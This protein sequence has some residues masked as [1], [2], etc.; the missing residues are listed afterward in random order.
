MNNL[1]GVVRKLFYAKRKVKW[2]ALALFIFSNSASAGVP[3]GP[4]IVLKSAYWLPDYL[5]AALRVHGYLGERAQNV[6]EVYRRRVELLIAINQ[7]A[8]E[9]RRS[10]L[11][12]IEF[13]QGGDDLFNLPGRP[14]RMAVTGTSLGSKVIFNLGLISDPGRFG[15]N[16]ALGLWVHELGHKLKAG[17]FSQEEIDQ[18]AAFVADHFINQMQIVEISDLKF[19]VIN[20]VPYKLEGMSST[21]A[22]PEMHKTV[23]PILA[24]LKDEHITDLGD[25][26]GKQLDTFA[27]PS[28]NRFESRRAVT[29]LVLLKDTQDEIDLM[30]ELRTSR[31]IKDPFR[32]FSMDDFGTNFIRSARLRL[33]KD[34]KAGRLEV[35]QY[36]DAP[37]WRPRIRDAEAEFVGPSISL[38]RRF[39]QFTLN[40]L[41]K[42]QTH[43]HAAGYPDSRFTVHALLDGEPI[44]LKAKVHYTETGRIGA[45]PDEIHQQE[46][47][48]R[49]RVT[50]DLFDVKG[51]ELELIGM[52]DRFFTLGQGLEGSSEHEQKRVPL[53][54][55]LSVTL[56][57]ES[58]L[59]PKPHSNTNR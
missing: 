53:R 50:I 12:R 40:L 29:E 14:P 24:L 43:F 34:L 6:R 17:R 27:P 28:S 49:G 55:P 35:I 59:A 31:Q 44:R 8:E 54:S 5:D 13:K 51:S 9:F 23:N 33:K 48:K 52:Q 30:L 37:L 45:A 4:Y 16:D 58:S 15:L 22:F 46:T 21:T 19:L 20:P 56:N 1:F 2:L 32:S 25:E 47:F 57:C 42:N 41:L 38:D 39:L 10:H 11:N 36:V 18:A 26:L 7:V 3:Y